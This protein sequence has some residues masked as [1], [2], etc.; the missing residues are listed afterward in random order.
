MQHNKWR[1]IISRDV[2]PARNFAIEESIFLSIASHK[3][4]NTIFLWRNKPS[5]IIGISENVNES[6]NLEVCKV[7]N[8]EVLRRRTGGGTVYHDMGNLNWSIMLEKNILKENNNIHN[9]YYDIGSIITNAL[10]N[11]SVDAY[12]N[13]PNSIFIDDK[14]ISGMAMYLKKNVVLCHGTLLINSNLDLLYKVL[15]KIKYEV[16]T[17]RKL[18][19]QTSVNILIESIIT[20]LETTYNC[21]VKIEELNE[22]EFSIYKQIKLS[23]YNPFLLSHKEY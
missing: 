14:K 20:S 9:I 17:L 3:S 10:Q 21:N 18:G 4:P 13:P 19:L 6:L 15:K 7:H 11:S 5:V 23:K 16:T 2:D 12:F 22:H 8:V 1:L